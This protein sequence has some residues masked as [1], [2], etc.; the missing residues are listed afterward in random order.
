MIEKIIYL[1]NAR[2]EVQVVS[3]DAIPEQRTIGVFAKY[4]DA[5]ELF[6]QTIESI[7]EELYDQ[8]SEQMLNVSYDELFADFGTM[9]GDDES[10]DGS[11]WWTF[12]EK[13]DKRDVLIKMFSNSAD[14]RNASATCACFRS[15]INM[16]FEKEDD[17]LGEIY[18][19][20]LVMPQVEIIAVPL[21]SDYIRK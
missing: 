8:F 20:I 21:Q 11:I 15:G 6:N 18:G 13:G 10:L 9:Q 5:A 4:E 19:N 16:T 3:W 14:L 2:E 7:G 12:D 17:L 1:V